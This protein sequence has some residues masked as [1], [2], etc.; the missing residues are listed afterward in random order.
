MK[1]ILKIIYLILTLMFFNVN[2]SICQTLTLSLENGALV[3]KNNGVVSDHIAN[4]SGQ[5]LD[6]KI[7]SENEVVVIRDFNVTTLYT[8]FKKND[9]GWM[10]ILTTSLGQT[11]QQKIRHSSTIP[12]NYLQIKDKL[13]TFKVEDIEKVNIYDNGVKTG[14]VNFE[15]IKE[16]RIKYLE[17]VK[18]FN[19]TQNHKKD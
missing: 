2:Y 3:L 7:L 16:Q 13:I 14:S 4:N 18:S 17:A 9:S 11:P 10:V 1:I 6:Y 12:K 15:A 5:I 8:H 19:S